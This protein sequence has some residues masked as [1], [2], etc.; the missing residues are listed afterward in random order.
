MGENLGQLWTSRPPWTLGTTCFTAVAQRGCFTETLT[1]NSKHSSNTF[2]ASYMGT[3]DE[4]YC[5][6]KAQGWVVKKKKA[7]MGSLKDTWGQSQQ[8]YFWKIQSFVCREGPLS[9]FKAADAPNSTTPVPYSKSMTMISR[10][11]PLT[12]GFQQETYGLI[13][14]NFL[15][16]AIRE[17]E[18]DGMPSFRGKAVLSKLRLQL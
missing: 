1:L 6:S 5:I 17:R 2:S 11:H 9:S 18:D 3:W 15:M 7:F 12:F 14:V 4:I 13:K 16:L 8:K 10:A